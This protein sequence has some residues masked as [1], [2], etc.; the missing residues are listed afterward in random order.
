MEAFIVHVRK[1]G[2]SSVWNKWR[3][4]DNQIP[5]IGEWLPGS[6]FETR[7]L[8]DI[9]YWWCNKQNV[10][11]SIS[12]LSMMMAFPTIVFSFFQYEG[13]KQGTLYQIL[14]YSSD[15]GVQRE[16]GHNWR[17]GIIINKGSVL[18]D[19]AGMWY[20]SLAFTKLPS[21][22][23]LIRK[24]WD[25]S[26]FFIVLPDSVWLQ[27][28]I[29]FSWIT[30]GFLVLNLLGNLRVRFA[31]YRYISLGNARLRLCRIICAVCMLILVLE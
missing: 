15:V 2:V 27:G 1:N 9:L 30:L 5:S 14:V 16:A 25:I 19:S 24:E 20:F 10:C 22:I 18:L 8:F 11:W 12:K 17:E 23:Q 26:W 4:M 13:L 31:L 3:N 21:F 28:F 7:N 29:L 6:F